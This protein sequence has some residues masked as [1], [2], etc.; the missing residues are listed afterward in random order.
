M[1]SA[2]IIFNPLHQSQKDEMEMEN[3]YIEEKKQHLFKEK[4]DNTLLKILNSVYSEI[5]EKNKKVEPDA[6][7]DKLRSNSS[8][9]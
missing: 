5:E 9:N 4:D 6:S 3:M 7:K 2:M 1:N 8:Y